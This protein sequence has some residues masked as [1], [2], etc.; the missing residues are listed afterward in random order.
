MN[1]YTHS[2]FRQLSR[3]FNDGRIMPNYSED[4]I[5]EAING[6][7]MA[8]VLLGRLFCVFMQKH[9]AAEAANKLIERFSKS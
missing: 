4:E 3:R 2:G 6:T 5:K 9:E 1:R 8:V 7:T